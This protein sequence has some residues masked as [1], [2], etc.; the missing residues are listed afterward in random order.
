MIKLTK[1]AYEDYLN[2]FGIGQPQYN[3]RG[4]PIKKFGGWM[5]KNDPI[6]FRVGYN[7]WLSEKTF[8]RGAL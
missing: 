3:L 4:T 2:E 7:E 8:K 5:R 6:Q 1:K